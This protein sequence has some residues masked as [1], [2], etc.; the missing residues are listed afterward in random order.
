MLR[1]YAKREFSPVDAIEETLARIAVLEPA[2]NAAVTLDADGGRR[3]AAEAEDRWRTGRQRSLEGI[4]FGVKDLLDIAG[5]PTA[6]GGNAFTRMA[7]IDAEVVH[8]LR[9]QGAIPM[10]KLR[11]NELGCGSL[12]NPHSGPVLNPWNRSRLT[13]GS[14]TGPAAAVAAGYFP[15]A[16]GT[17]AAGSVRLP[18]AH[19]GLNGLKPT[20]GSVPADGTL[21]LSP[22][23]DSIGVLACD[24]TDLDIVR[25]AITRS[26]RMNTGMSPGR[27]GVAMRSFHECGTDIARATWSAIDTLAELGATLVEVPDAPP[28]ISSWVGWTI[29]L[30]ESPSLAGVLP[31]PIACSI[32]RPSWMKPSALGFLPE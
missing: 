8:R 9:E 6:F 3:M 2:I 7:E 13:G 4:P 32:M 22:T 26:P 14:S 25:G 15:F 29:L 23:M 18:A 10:C 11:T 30:S 12:I 1:A 5:M 28:A 27:L 24:A 19:C 16:I 17:D 31:E 21:V 20:N